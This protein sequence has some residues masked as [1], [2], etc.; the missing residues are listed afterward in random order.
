VEKLENMVDKA[1]GYEYNL[2]KEMT[3]LYLFLKDIEVKYKNTYSPLLVKQCL[4]T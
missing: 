3:T 4:K 2:L 1:K